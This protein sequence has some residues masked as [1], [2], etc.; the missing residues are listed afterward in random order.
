MLDVNIAAD[1]RKITTKG[2]VNQLRR[3]GKVPGVLYS[4]EM[5]PI[6]FSV[7]EISLNPVVYT[8]E[9]HLVNLKI[10]ENKEIKS[11]LKDV[12]FDPVTDKI[13][14]V[15]F[16]A[17]TVGQVLQLQVPINFVGQAV[18]VKSGGSLQQTFN[19]LDIEC[20]PRHI[21]ES[22]EVNITNLEIG[23]SI[24]VADLE[25]ENIK[26]LNPEDTTI[27]AVTAPRA[28]EVEETADLLEE[29]TESAEPEVISKGKSEEE[30]ENS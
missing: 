10:G 13:I 2:A 29:E 12:Q 1:E 11:I 19:K 18:G 16:Q 20:L 25:F 28:E 9:M 6:N 5:E 8:T 3:D 21:P 27:I 30:S 4:N 14:H 24:R 26:I 17:I 15:D 7:T 22:L 23:D